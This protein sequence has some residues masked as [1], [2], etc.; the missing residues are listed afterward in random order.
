MNFSN[1]AFDKQ[2]NIFPY[3]LNGNSNFLS[4]FSN[5]VNILPQFN[6]FCQ[7]T[8]VIPI[9]QPSLLYTLNYNKK[10]ERQYQSLIHQNFY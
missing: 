7:I 6:P 2:I 3:L 8:P 10:E 5:S 9:L 1:L 4:L